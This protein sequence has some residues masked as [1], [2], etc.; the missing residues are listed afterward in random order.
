[1]PYWCKYFTPLAIWLMIFVACFSLKLNCFFLKAVTFTIVFQ[2]SEKHNISNL[3]Y[4]HNSA[5]YSICF[6]LFVKKR[7][8]DM[9]SESVFLKTLPFH[10]SFKLQKDT[11][12]KCSS[13]S[14]EFCA[15]YHVVCRT[16]RFLRSRRLVGMGEK[17][18]LQ[19]RI[20]Q[21]YWAE[22]LSEVF[23]ECCG[24]SIASIMR[25]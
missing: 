2:K 14:K 9:V 25:L 11:I 6:A 15:I 8:Q 4:Y 21:Q 13:S 17:S 24:P 23:C 20:F 12:F 7:C 19:D 22:N 3:I 16:C 10:L 1:M 18:G 5:A